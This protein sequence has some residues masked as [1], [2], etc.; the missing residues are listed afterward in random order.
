[1]RMRT[2][3]GSYTLVATVLPGW[4]GGCL[5][6]TPPRAPPAGTLLLDFSHGQ[7]PSAHGHGPSGLGVLTL[8][9]AGGQ[10]SVQ[11][12]SVFMWAPHRGELML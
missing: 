8:P 4:G 12:G 7:V 2:W 9:G 3:P 6:T 11:V 1:M 5:P 10:N